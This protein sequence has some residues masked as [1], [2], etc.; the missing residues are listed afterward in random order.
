MSFISRVTE[1]INLFFRMIFVNKKYTLVAFIGLGVSLSLVTTSLIFLYSYQY[2]AFNKYVREHPQK[3]IVITP[4]N[5]INS[6]GIEESLVPNLNSIVDNALSSS[7]LGG[8]II[9]RSWFSRRAVVVPFKNLNDYNNTN[10]FATSLVGV[11]AEYLNILEKYILPGGQ[12]PSNINETLMMVRS[13]T[14]SNS[15]FSRGAQNIFVIT[16]PFNIWAG[17]LLGIPA[18]GVPMNV[19][20]LINVY[21]VQ[22]DVNMTSDDRILINNLLSMLENDEML[23]TFHQNLMYFTSGLIGPPSLVAQNQQAYMGSILFNLNEI[24]AFRI[25]DEI[26]K[27]ISFSEELRSTIELTDYTNEVHIDLD[28]MIILQQFSTEFQIFKIFTLLFMIPIISMALSLTTYSSNLVKKRRKQQLALLAQRGASR[29]EMM[30]M[31]SIELLIF[32]IIAIL[33]SFIIA[34]PFSYLV[35]KSDGFLSFSGPAILPQLFI[36]IVEIIL[37]AGFV[38][39]ILVNIGNI[40]NLSRL[41]QEEAFNERINKKPFWEKFY[42]DIFF[43]FIGITAWII[44][45]IQLKNADVSVVFAQILGAPAPI[46]VIIGSI[47]LMARLYP[48]LTKWL[49]KVSWKFTKLELASLSLKGLSRRRTGTMRSVV[50]VMLTFTMAVT[51]I[52]I[53]DTYMHFDYENAGYSLGADIVIT[54]VT[55][56]DVDFKETIENIEGVIGTTY[57]ARLSYNPISRGSVTYYYT[58]IGVD[59]NKFAEVAYFDKEYIDGNLKELLPLLETPLDS[60]VSANVFVHPEQTKAYDLAIGD[61]FNIYYPYWSG[62]RIVEKN[63]TVNTVGFYNFWPNLYHSEPDPT[64]TN[65]RVGLVTSISNI[66][67]LTLDSSK[68]IMQMYV[69]VDDDYVVADVAAAVKEKAY[70]RRME[71]VD[72][73]VTIAAGSL[74][75]SVLYGALNSNFLASLMI[76]ILAMAMM[77]VIHSFERAN[78]VGI[79]KAIGISPRQLFAFFFTESFSVVVI[80]SLAG[81]LLGLLS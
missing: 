18:A 55:R 64:S 2:D 4:G 81:I 27:I 45:S 19:T 60:G 16:N 50:L 71:N 25:D 23:I 53:P 40:W 69:D 33:I 3:Q 61:D 57:V 7:D 1:K 49:S 74:R 59:I 6:Y 37:V 32:T 66:Y 48:Y 56:S 35:L 42:I 79:M 29:G 65:F 38:V 17:I 72:E 75:A 51:S 15:N 76:L 80:G 9:T 62:G 44:T 54:G 46:V 39:S 10:L 30:L 24:D 12:L 34:Y 36:F 52:I 28:I 67:S 63:Y 5:M 73:E 13:D 41:T 8:R 21:D 22:N 78:E 47:L 11:S 14:I 31:L 43:L 70:G 58:I 77:T 26:S 68:V 20:G